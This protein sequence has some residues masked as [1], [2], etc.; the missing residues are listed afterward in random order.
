MVGGRDG[1]IIGRAVIVR[2]VVVIQ[3][4]NGKQYFGVEGVYPGEVRQ[5][6]GFMLAIAQ[7]D[8]WVLRHKV[9]RWNRS[10]LNIVRKRI[11]GNLV[12]IPA[13]GSHEAKLV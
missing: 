3:R 4:R 11:V 13:A 10:I 2:A 7:S 12:V 5:H 8:A 9:I 6:I 1:K